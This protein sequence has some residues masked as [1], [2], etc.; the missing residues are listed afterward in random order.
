M[1]DRLIT[2]VIPN[3]NICA[4]VTFARRIF[5]VGSTLRGAAHRNERQ[6]DSAGY[7]RDEFHGASLLAIIIFPSVHCSYGRPRTQ[8]IRPDIRGF[9]MALLQPA[10]ARRYTLMHTDLVSR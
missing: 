8:Y 2:A 3:S 10:S 9:E 4:C 5:L 1:I 6:D 7:G